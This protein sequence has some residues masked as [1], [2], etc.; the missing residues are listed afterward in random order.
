VRGGSSDLVSEEIAREFV[1]QVPNA[2]FVA[3]HKVA[4]EVNDPFTEQM[5]TLL[6]R[7]STGE[8]RAEGHQ[9]LLAGRVGFGLA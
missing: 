6:D 5:V 4:G 3:T 7:P 2:R 8:F 9:L 1:D